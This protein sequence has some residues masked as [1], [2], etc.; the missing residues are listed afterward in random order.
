M[1]QTLFILLK[2]NVSAGDS[3]SFFLSYMKSSL[4]ST[5]TYDIVPRVQHNHQNYSQLQYMKTHIE[6]IIKNNVGTKIQ[7]KTHKEQVTKK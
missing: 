5:K 7:M 4:I 2:K 6:Q 3:E 1:L